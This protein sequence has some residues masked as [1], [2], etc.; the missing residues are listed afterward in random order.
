MLIHCLV[1]PFSHCGNFPHK[2]QFRLCKQIGA[3]G[4]RRPVGELGLPFRILV[5]HRRNW[6][7]DTE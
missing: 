7:I 1:N 2:L 5:L 4:P 6:E 3:T